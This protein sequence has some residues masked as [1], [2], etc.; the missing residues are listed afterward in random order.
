M[1]DFDDLVYKKIDFKMIIVVIAAFIFAFYVYDLLFGERSYTRLLD[2]Q[3][4]YKE[5]KTH[6]ETLKKRNEKLQKEYF[7]LKELQGGE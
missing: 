3:S 4:E 1:F 5:L 6:V 2:L 7:E